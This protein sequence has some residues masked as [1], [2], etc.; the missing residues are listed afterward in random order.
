MQI[1]SYSHLFFRD[2]K[3]EIRQCELSNCRIKD[4]VSLEF[5][6]LL[7]DYLPRAAFVWPNTTDK[8]I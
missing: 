4:G 2:D 8:S 7:V 5:L 3:K 1:H 6:L